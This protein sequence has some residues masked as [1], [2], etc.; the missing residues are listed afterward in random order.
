[1]AGHLCVALRHGGSAVDIEALVHHPERSIAEIAAGRD[2]RRH[3]GQV[4]LDELMRPDRLAELSAHLRI[5]Q[6]LIER[7]LREM[8]GLQPDEGAV[9]VPA[10]VE[11]LGAAVRLDDVGQR[12]AAIGEH[13]FAEEALIE[14]DRVD[15]SRLERRLVALDDDLDD[16]LA[17]VLRRFFGAGDEDNVASADIGDPHLLAVQHG[18]V[19]LAAKAGLDTARVRARVRLGR[20]GASDLLAG[21]DVRQE[22]R[23]LLV[24]AFG[25][26]PRGKRILRQHRHADRRRNLLEGEAAIQ[27]GQARAAAFFRQARGQNALLRDCLENLDQ[28]GLRQSAVLGVRGEHGA[29]DP[30]DQAPRRRD[31]ILLIRR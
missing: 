21:N 22:T 23:L 20:A 6:R 25:I 14:A 29:D 7:A 4:L 30:I 9:Q 27:Q 2:R 5:F 17:A 24:A 16:L 26:E 19:A 18:H 13:G 11:H 12:H 28:L 8:H 1:M 31:D 3:I 15:L 10:L